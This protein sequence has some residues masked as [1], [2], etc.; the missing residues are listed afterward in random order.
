MRSLIAG[1]V[2]VA[3]MVPWVASA[4]AARAQVQAGPAA[5]AGA[6]RVFLAR[7][8]APYARPGMTQRA[9][10]RPRE[11]F[12]PRLAAA[13]LRDAAESRRRNEV[14]SIDAD[15][16]CQCQDGNPFRI[17][18]SNLRVAG[19]MARARVRFTNFEPTTVDY[20]L[21]K[22]PA[23]WRIQDLGAP[24]NPSFRRLLRVR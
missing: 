24:G 15:P 2:L 14:G 10:D 20:V 19:N 16:F 11:W 4:Q 3:A 22:T 7:L 9:L 6:V 23:G 17:T 1:G 12:E 18:V 8:Y 5:E 21:V 13:I